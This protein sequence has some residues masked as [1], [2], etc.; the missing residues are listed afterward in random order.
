MKHIFSVHSPVTFLISWAVIENLNLPEKDVL[1]LTH[2][3]NPPLEKYKTLESI[4]SYEGKSIF[5]KLFQLNYPKSF[6]A[7][8]YQTI[9]NEPF[10]AYVDMM[11]PRQMML[12]TNENCH[13]FC[14]IEEGNASYTDEDDL[15]SVTWREREAP[16]RMSYSRKSIFKALTRISRGYS[17]KLLSMPYHFRAYSHFKNIKY[18]CFSSSAFPKIP[19]EKK[20]VVTPHTVSPDLDKMSAGYELNNEFIW[21]DG[22]NSRFT[23][24]PEEVYHNAIDKAIEKLKHQLNNQDQINVKLRP[25]LKDPENNYL[26][27]RLEKEGYAVNI[28]EDNMVIEAVLLKSE[29]CTVIGN[30]SSVL[31]YAAI[32]GHK[33][34][35]LYGLFEK[36]VF[37]YFD[38]MPGYWE[39]VEKL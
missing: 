11:H 25:G 33:A 12:A 29:D 27:S 18:Y 13:S 7:S 19:V 8:L 10:K 24:L 6:D 4:D 22:S 37:T 3:Y 2:N 38:Q 14:F 1:L 26:V 28:M 30:L 5:R 9:G 34:Y 20:E 16:W 21:I 39:K 17:L 35:S 32:F 31:F 15:D 23:G 36:K